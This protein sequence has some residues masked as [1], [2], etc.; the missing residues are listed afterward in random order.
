MLNLMSG[1]SNGFTT[2]LYILLAV[3]VF[4]ILIL[5]HEL[6]HYI[7]AR[8]FKVTIKEFSIGMGPKLISYTSKKTNIRY[9]LRLLPLG[10]YVSM[11]GEDEETDDPNALNR[12]KPWKRL[13]IMCAGAVTNIFIG[14]VLMFILVLTPN[15]RIGGTTIASIDDTY[16]QTQEKELLV[17]DRI[18]KVGNTRVHFYQELA[19]EIMNQGYEPLDIT[20]VRNGEEIKLDKVSFP[21]EEQDGVYFGSMFFSVFSMKKTFG[22]VVAYSFYSSFST[23]KMIWESLISLI[24]GRFGFSSLSGPVGVTKTV[25]E[26]ARAGITSLLYIIVF[27][28]MNLGVFNLLPIPSLDGSRILFVLIEMVRGKPINPK[29]EGYIHFAGIVLLF[30]LLIAIT[31]KDIISLLT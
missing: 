12:K 17:G 10:G 24:T 4:G 13:I 1:V 15:F 3:F 21:T 29:Y 5:V 30:I 20:V 28:S 2:F 16:V 7:A 19:Y 11:V 22:N 26:S 23:I 9:S 8:C 25:A 18:T 6:G 31:F 14:V 27:I